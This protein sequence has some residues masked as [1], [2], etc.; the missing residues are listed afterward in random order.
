MKTG[1]TMYV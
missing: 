1:K